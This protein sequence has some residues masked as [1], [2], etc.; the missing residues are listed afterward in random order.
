VGLDAGHTVSILERISLGE[1]VAIF[2][3]GPCCQLAY[4]WP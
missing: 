2:V 4:G 1:N 3:E